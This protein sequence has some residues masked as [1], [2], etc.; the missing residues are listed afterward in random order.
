MTRL[1]MTAV[2]AAG[3]LVLSGCS[4]AGWGLPSGGGG[5]VHLTYALWDA[6]QQ[7]GY[8]RSIDE[9]EKQHPN[10]DV[11]IEQVPYASY[12]QKITA[13]YIS[14]NA[15]DVFW[16]NT[17]WL[18]DW[19]S[20]GLLADITDRVKAANIDLGQYYSS[21]VKL[22]EKDGRLY[23]LPKDWDTIAQYYNKDYLA[24]IGVRSVPTDLSWNPVDG[25]SYLKFLKRITTDTSGRNALDP[26]FDPRSVKT[27]AIASTNDPQAQLL[28]FFAMNGGSMLPAPFAK[29][30]SLNSPQN[31]QTLTFLTRMLQQAHV[32]VPAGQTGPNGDDT[33]AQTLFAS[34][35]TAIWQTGDWQTLGLSGL[36]KFTIGVAPLPSGPK[37]RISVFNGLTDGIASN[38]EHPEEAW[39]LVQWLAGEQSQRLMGSGGYVWPAIE[40]LDPLFLDYWRRK[41]I[42][43][44]PFLDEA[45]GK[46]V[47]FPVAT[48]LAEALSD[49][50][51]A[52]GPTYLGQS[53]P[54]QGLR[55]AQRILDYR[56]SYT[57]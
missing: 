19:V 20:G 25:G 16:V 8:Q 6:N 37:G 31:R 52:L 27:Y 42:D 41:G 36:S 22:H 29:K 24:T 26:K 39:Q 51:I 33:N 13:Q 50:S 9:F 28:S 45:K 49:V 18:G 4:A 2:A 43:L 23:G 12:Q 57:K 30:S 5:K 40:K 21:L 46:T 55:D 56:I 34:G 3:V 32:A 38:T 53:S 14:G 48:G 47:N 1:R 7:K 15:P 17:P 10:I 11:T 44:T 35:R 54:A